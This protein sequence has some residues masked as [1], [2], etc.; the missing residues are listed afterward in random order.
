M[1]IRYAISVLL[2]G[3]QVALAQDPVGAQPQGST[4]VQP[5]THTSL[6]MTLNPAP[7]LSEVL[8]E[9]LDRQLADSTDKQTLPKARWVSANLA[10]GR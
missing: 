10:A 1:K 2:L 7:E 3:S 8:A 6:P 5:D 9:Q 4:R